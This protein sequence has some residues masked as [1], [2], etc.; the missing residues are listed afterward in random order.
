VYLWDAG[1]WCGVSGVLEDAQRPA[2]AHAG[3]GAARV[4]SAWLGT[5]TRTLLPCYQRT[6]RTWTSWRRP[7]GTVTWSY[8]EHRLAA[9]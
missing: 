3:E 8:R 9:S 6:G 7:D 4:E 2:A 5:C 1:R